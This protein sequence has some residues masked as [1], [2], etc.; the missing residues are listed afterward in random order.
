MTFTKVP[1]LAKNADLATRKAYFEEFSL[2][3]R[4][5]LDLANE[6]KMLAVFSIGLAYLFLLAQMNALRLNLSAKRLTSTRKTEIEKEIYK[7][8]TTKLKVW[9][10]EM[11]TRCIEEGNTKEYDAARFFKNEVDF[12]TSVGAN[13]LQTYGFAVSKEE[14]DV[15]RTIVINLMTDEISSRKYL[16]TNPKGLSIWTYL[17]FGPDERTAQFRGAKRVAGTIVYPADS[18]LHYIDTVNSTQTTVEDLSTQEDD[19][20]TVYENDRRIVT[21]DTLRSIQYSIEDYNN[22]VGRFNAKDKNIVKKVPYSFTVPSGLKAKDEYQNWVLLSEDETMPDNAKAILIDA[23]A[24]YEAPHELKSTFIVNPDDAVFEAQ[25]CVPSH[26]W[27]RNDHSLKER[28]ELPKKS[29]PADFSLISQLFA[30]L[31]VSDEAEPMAAD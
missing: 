4:M 11:I 22:Y 8:L 27:G 6:E 12:R 29:V 20:T 14:L 13:T 1:T 10:S 30:Q 19:D 23:L 7:L 9:Y 25:R 26:N 24:R 5:N 28:D 17:K 15:F 21:D 3:R 2:T 16:K 31:S 18:M